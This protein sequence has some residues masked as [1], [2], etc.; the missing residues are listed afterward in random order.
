MKFSTALGLVLALVITQAAWGQAGDVKSSYIKSTL[1]DVLA[2]IRNEYVYQVKDETLLAGAVKEMA[3]VD[4]SLAGKPC[5]T[6]GAFEA[7]FDSAY[8]RNPAA[9]SP[10]GEAAIRGMV[11]SLGDPYSLFLS[12]KE[13]DY[14]RRVS[15]G[16]SFAGIG[17]ELAVKNGKLVITAP[18]EGSPAEKAGIRPGDLVV[19]VGG[20]SI[21][22]KDYYE[23]LSMF[24]G[25]KG[26]ALLLSV[27]RGPK[28]LDFTIVRDN[29]RFDPVSAKL[30][31]SKPPVGYIKIPYF[32][33]STDSEVRRALDR[34]AE[35]GVKAVIFDVRNNPGG[36]FGSSLRMASL[37]VKGKPLIKVQKKGGAPSDIY[38]EKGPSYQFRTVILINEGSAS[39]SEVFACAL[40]QN[41]LATLV[42]TRSFGKALVQ[43]VYSLPG[44]AALKLTT[45]RYYTPRGDDI[46]FKGLAPSVA[47]ESVYPVPPVTKDPVVLKGVEVLIR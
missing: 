35:K 39:A 23:V 31:G 5:A 18:L 42:G 20:Q 2:T 29:I 16:E 4:A 37:F 46:L 9:A 19:K 25:L 30:L 32:G 28:V 44:N 24:D 45:S 13:W 1:G 34:L 47:A 33:Q 6:W 11:K 10:L 14:Y 26:S 41:G 21:E 17:V 40:A 7:L 15:S 27:R 12:P 36:D 8:G 43:S 38:P 22:G 3:R